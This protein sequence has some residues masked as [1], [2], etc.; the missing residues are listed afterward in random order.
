M[1]WQRASQSQRFTGLRP[2]AADIII[3]VRFNGLDLSFLP[4]FI[5]SFFFGVIFGD[6]VSLLLDRIPAS[7]SSEARSGLAPEESA[8]FK[9]DF[10]LNFFFIFF[11]VTILLRLEARLR[12][13][14]GPELGLE[15]PERLGEPGLDLV[16]LIEPIERERREM[17]GD[18]KKKII[19]N[20]LFIVLQIPGY[21][22]NPRHPYCLRFKW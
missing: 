9:D 8:N 7:G 16:H 20:Y 12:D 14:V 5:F 10:L 4:W 6:P 19:K 17:D 2:E 18:L 13:V 21:I 15:G 11:G 3:L 22:Q 1:L